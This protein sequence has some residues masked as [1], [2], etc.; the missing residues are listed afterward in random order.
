MS[1]D[2]EIGDTAGWETCATT[3]TEDAMGRFFQQSSFSNP[4]HR[5]G[6]SCSPLK[7]LPLFPSVPVL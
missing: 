6:V 2:L 3:Q 1:A 4:V 5:T 7:I